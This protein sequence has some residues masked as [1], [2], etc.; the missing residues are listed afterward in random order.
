MILPPYMKTK[1]VEHLAFHDALT[2]LPNRRKF[3]KDL[4]AILNTAQTNANDVAVIFL[5][6]D[7]FKN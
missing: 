4:K 1:Q 2:G 7:R 3:E 5:D 6:L